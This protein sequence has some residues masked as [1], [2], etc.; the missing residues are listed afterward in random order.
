MPLIFLDMQNL[1]KLTLPLAL[2]FGLKTAVA[3]SIVSMPSVETKMVQLSLNRLGYSVG[4]SG[5][6]GIYGPDTRAAIIKYQLDKRVPAT[7]RL[8]SVQ[9]RELRNLLPKSRLDSIDA[10][11]IGPLQVVDLPHDPLF[12][13]KTAVTD[14]GIEE[15]FTLLLDGA[16]LSWC[17]NHGERHIYKVVRGEIQGRA[18]FDYGNGGNVNRITIMP[19]DFQINALINQGPLPRWANGEVIYAPPNL[20]A[21]NSETLSLSKNDNSGQIVENFA[22]GSKMLFSIATESEKPLKLEL[23]STSPISLL[24]DL[25]SCKLEPKEGRLTGGK[26]AATVSWV[27]PFFGSASL[28]IKNVSWRSIEAEIANGNTS[29]LL[30]GAKA[31]YPDF[32]QMPSVYINLSS[33]EYDLLHINLQSNPTQYVGHIETAKASRVL[34]ASEKAID[35]INSKDS[36]SHIVMPDGQAT[37]SVNEYK[38]F[39]SNLLSSTEAMYQEFELKEERGI[40]ILATKAHG[41]LK[42]LSNLFG[43]QKNVA[44]VR[45]PL[46]LAN[47]A[48]LVQELLRIPYAS[49]SSTKMSQVYGTAMSRAYVD[50]DDWVVVGLAQSPSTAMQDVFL[51]KSAFAFQF[52]RGKF[53]SSKPVEIIVEH[54]NA[55]TRAEE[56]IMIEYQRI[57]ESYAAN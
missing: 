46:S 5:P 23:S 35:A 17:S 24:L 19:R 1:L 7:G 16:N 27:V 12:L 38:T 4:K 30:Y 43:K 42:E 8:T 49:A 34:T 11:T 28:K 52:S 47:G 29:I 41:P 3:Q 10:L 55:D 56:Q 2:V 54:A 40:K 22:N 21:Y 57:G 25:A 44:I 31:M 15:L 13:H 9:I 6:D 39:L 50:L 14:V 26:G 51:M 48:H 45:L 36:D 53:S 20:S 33:I 32:Q 18:S 37:I